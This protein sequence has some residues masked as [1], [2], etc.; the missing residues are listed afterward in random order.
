M[1]QRCVYSEC[2]FVTDTFKQ[3][4][5]DY[6]GYISPQAG[7]TPSEY[8]K[9]HPEGL[10]RTIGDDRVYCGILSSS[11][12]RLRLAVY[13]RIEIFTIN[14][15]RLQSLPYPNSNPFNTQS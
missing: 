12:T 8:V 6:L 5:Y 11:N 9:M 7:L 14:H 3:C 15:L 13:D 4:T 1:N 10:T 2:I